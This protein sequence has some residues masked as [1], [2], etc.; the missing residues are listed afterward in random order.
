MKQALLWTT[1]SYFGPLSHQAK[2]T[3]ISKISAPLAL[4]GLLRMNVADEKQ[5]H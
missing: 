4:A 2:L 5:E 1:V 3:I